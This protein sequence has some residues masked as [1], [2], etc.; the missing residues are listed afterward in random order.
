[1][2]RFY[3]FIFFVLI[4]FIFLRINNVLAT[5]SV[6]IKE[7]EQ[8]IE[9]TVDKTKKVDS[10]GIYKMPDDLTYS[11]SSKIY[12][13]GGVILFKFEDDSYQLIDM[14]SKDIVKSVNF[15]GDSFNIIVTFY[16]DN[17]MINGNVTLEKSVDYEMHNTVLG[18]GD[19]NP[20][21]GFD[22]K[23]APKYSYI[24]NY[25]DLDLRRGVLDI[26][27]EDGTLGVV[28][29]TDPE[30]VVEGFNNK[31]PGIQELTVR[32]KG[33]EKKFNVNIIENYNPELNGK[34][35][36]DRKSENTNNNTQAPKFVQINTSKGES[37]SSNNNS[38]NSNS[39]INKN[40]QNRP[41][42]TMA[43]GL[44]PQTGAIPI[45][46]FSILFFTII[47]IIIYIK[48]IIMK[49]GIRGI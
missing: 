8:N 20:I 2:K 16:Y 7:I 13:K 27:Y 41:D 47:L 9:Q 6:Q 28:K 34:L 1:M 33:F 24:Q 37:N 22:I 46:V 45:V 18:A 17:V 10:M 30:V 49:R 43:K 44:L 21:R 5:S 31:I 26:F 4:L 35:S 25:E 14:M 29:M 15:D 12:L 19:E 3:N 42:N 39:N 23:V 36:V 11:D 32:Y 38:S 40:G 48:N